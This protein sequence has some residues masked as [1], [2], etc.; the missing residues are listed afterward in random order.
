MINYYIEY[1]VVQQ[2]E[3][4]DGGLVCSW[5]IPTWLKDLKWP[6]NSP[7]SASSKLSQLR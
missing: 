1:F 7:P 3:R 4:N 6:S 5:K 2:A